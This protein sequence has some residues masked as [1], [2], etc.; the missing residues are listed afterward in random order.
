MILLLRILL[1]LTPLVVAVVYFLLYSKAGFR[2]WIKTL[3]FLPLAGPWA[4]SVVSCGGLFCGDNYIAAH[5]PAA[6]EESL[7]RAFASDLIAF[8]A[9]LIPLLLLTFARWPNL[10]SGS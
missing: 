8:L 10:R 1:F 2:G 4:A 7:L 5:T 3:A 9:L 6:I